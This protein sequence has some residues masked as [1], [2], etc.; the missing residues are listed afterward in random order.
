MREGRKG[1]L[2]SLSDRIDNE[3]YACALRELMNRFHHVT[4]STI[5]YVVSAEFN[6]ATSALRTTRYSDYCRARLCS[7]LK[8]SHPYSA[9]S[10]LDEN[11]LSP[12]KRASCE[13]TVVSGSKRDRHNCSIRRIQA[14]RYAPCSR[15]R[16]RP[17][18]RMRS[19]HIERY[20]PVPDLAACNARPDLH[21]GAGCRITNYPGWMRRRCR[22]TVYQIATLKRNGLDGNQHIA[23][24]NSGFLKIDVFQN[25]RDAGCI[26]GC[27]FHKLSNPRPNQAVD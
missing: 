1:G 6:Q 16:H 14:I 27:C 26:V 10:R 4:T 25:T 5:Y 7:E 24:F 22:A 18:F 17:E 11:S 12:F 23:W 2:Q 15:L 8:S 9:G 20:D 3:V 21:H 13:K 19:L